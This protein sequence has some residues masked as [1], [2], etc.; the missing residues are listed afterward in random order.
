M[1]NLT[2]GPIQLLFICY[3]GVLFEWN[4]NMPIFGPFMMKSPHVI[5]KGCGSFRI[6]KLW[7]MG[8]FPLLFKNCQVI[9]I[10]ECDFV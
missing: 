9:I 7:R 8:V 1:S 5:T 3:W 2:V 6:V 4:T 10:I